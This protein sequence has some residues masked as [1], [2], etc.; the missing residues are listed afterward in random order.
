MI[1][2]KC[3][4]VAHSECPWNSTH[5]ELLSVNFWETL[6]TLQRHVKET[7]KLGTFWM[8]PAFS[9]SFPKIYQKRFTVGG[10]SRTFWM[11]HSGTFWGH[12]SGSFWVLLTGNT[13]IALLGTSQRKFWMSH[14]G[15]F[16]VLS[17]GKL[18]MFPW[19]SWWGHPGHMIWNTV[20]VPGGFLP[21]TLSISLWWTCDVPAQD[22]TSCPQC[23]LLLFSC[24]LNANCFEQ[25]MGQMHRSDVND[26]LPECHY[27]DRLWGYTIRTAKMWRNSNRDQ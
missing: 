11:C 1:A 15:K 13:V 19:C 7:G 10:I 17:L 24:G 22:T 26:I 3:S 23:L 5:G 9:Q 12:C 27:N 4:R 21:G 2:P 18:W 20:N 8:Y 25:I 16:W 6:G 14:L